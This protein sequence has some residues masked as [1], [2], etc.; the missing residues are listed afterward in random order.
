M[1]GVV[2]VAVSGHP[3]KNDAQWANANPEQDVAR[4]HGC[5]CP[6]G[7]RMYNEYGDVSMRRERKGI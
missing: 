4:V 2:V 5:A 7:A 3:I 6:R 1:R